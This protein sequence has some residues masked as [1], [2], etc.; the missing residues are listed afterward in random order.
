MKP[1]DALTLIALGALCGA[2]Y[3]FMRVLLR[4]RRTFPSPEKFS[5]RT[6]VNSPCGAISRMACNLTS[7]LAIP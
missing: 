4:F 3:L 6:G 2:S 7:T 5:T 1:S